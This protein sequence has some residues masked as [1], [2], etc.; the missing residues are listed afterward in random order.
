VGA[1][2]GDARRARALTGGQRVEG[3]APGGVG[4]EGSQR[5]EQGGY[6]GGVR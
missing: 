4:A 5:G 1:G 3:D 6:V 2:G